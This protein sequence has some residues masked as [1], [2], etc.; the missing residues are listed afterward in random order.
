MEKLNDLSYSDLM[1]IYNFLEI[2]KKIVSNNPELFNKEEI[3][4]II[5]KQKLIWNELHFRIDK[6]KI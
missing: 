4:T 2:R 6:L 1:S 5:N 3:H